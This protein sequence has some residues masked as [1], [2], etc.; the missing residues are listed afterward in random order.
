MT[1]HY[2]TPLLSAAEQRRVDRKITEDRED[3]RMAQQSVLQAAPEAAAPPVQHRSAP[4]LDDGGELAQAIAERLRFD[5][6]DDAHSRGASRCREEVSEIIEAQRHAHERHQ[7]E[8]ISEA[9]EAAA[10]RKRVPEIVERSMRHYEHERLTTNAEFAATELLTALDRHHEAQAL[11]ALTDALSDIDTMVSD[12]AREVL[13]DARQAADRLA[14]AGFTVDVSLDQIVDGD[15]DGA[16]SAVRLWR[17]AVA[18]WTEVQVVRQWVAAA[19]D[20]GFTVKRGSVTLARPP[21]VKSGAY[22]RAEDVARTNGPTAEDLALLSQFA[23]MP[24]DL[25]DQGSHAVLRWWI[26]QDEGAKPAA[27]GISA[28]HQGSYV[29]ED[30]GA[31][32]QAGE[33]STDEH[34][35]LLNN[36]VV[37]AW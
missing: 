26:G 28:M 3:R 30:Q 6:L 27:A 36:D 33:G 7:R 29:A 18:R 14:L 5:K 13:K 35:E 21:R 11:Q 17:S 8:L 2:E 31:V 4:G 15:D 23:T 20:R 37:D 1:T 9:W 22:A 24:R 12:A 19:L 16:I 32:Q 25:A 10:K 34:E